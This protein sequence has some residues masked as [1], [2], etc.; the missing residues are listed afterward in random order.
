MLGLGEVA[1][2]GSQTGTLQDGVV[3]VRNW[4]LLDIPGVGNS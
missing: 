1:W 2:A 4:G 3:G